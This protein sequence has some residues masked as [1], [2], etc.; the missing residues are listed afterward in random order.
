MV[1]ATS[2]PSKLIEMGTQFGAHFLALFSW[3]SRIVRFVKGAQVSVHGRTAP[4][5]IGVLSQID[6]PHNRTFPQ[7]RSYEMSSKSGFNFAKLDE[8]DV[9]KNNIIC[10]SKTN[11]KS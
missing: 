2:C 9:V 4:W 6:E 3:K 8:P 1:L 11:E 5:G 7:N 10:I